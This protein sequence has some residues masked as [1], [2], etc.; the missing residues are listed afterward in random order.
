MRKKDNMGERRRTKTKEINGD[1]KGKEREKTEEGPTVLKV[2]G[3][4]HI[5]LPRDARKFSV[6][7][8]MYR[9]NMGWVTGRK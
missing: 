6:R 9:G 1:K 3:Q 2:W 8:L 4:M 5:V 7:P